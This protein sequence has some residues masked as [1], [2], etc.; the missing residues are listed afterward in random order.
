MRLMT[1]WYVRRFLM[2]IGFH[3]IC[4]K[5]G[6][7]KNVHTLLTYT[8]LLLQ[9]LPTAKWSNHRPAEQFYT[10][11]VLSIMSSPFITRH[12]ELTGQSPGLRPIPSEDFFFREHHDVGTKIRKSEID[13]K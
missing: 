12:G 3:A 1:V 5:S 10:I 7:M 11:E 2:L 6:N 8:L 9:I 4:V 13:S